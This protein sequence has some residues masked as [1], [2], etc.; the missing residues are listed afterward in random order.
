VRKIIV[1]CLVSLDGYYEGK[2]RNLNALF[3]YFHPDYAGDQNFDAYNLERLRA[4]DTL[5][6]GGRSNFLGNMEYW[7]HVTDD[8]NATP[9]RREFARLM[10]PMEKVIVSDKLTPAE[11]GP[12]QNTRVVKLADA[13]SAIAALKEQ[14]GRDIFIYGSRILWND[15]LVHD[16]VDE[17]HFMIFPLIAGEGTPLFVGRPPVSLKLLSSRTWQGSGN[18]LAC[19][20]VERKK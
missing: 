9:I 6:W 19:Y 10:N 18:I 5:L 11:F 4:A 7:P 14:P 3:D 17:L 2:D 13:H 16:L 1:S 12:W 8:P 15:L 20:R